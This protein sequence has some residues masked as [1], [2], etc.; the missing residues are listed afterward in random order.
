PDLHLSGAYRGDAG[1]P[2]G[3]AGRI[4]IDAAPSKWGRESRAPRAQTPERSARTRGDPTE[5]SYTKTFSVADTEAKVEAARG[6]QSFKPGDRRDGFVYVYSDDIELTINVGLATGRPI[7]L[8]GPSGSG[9]SSL[10][11]NVAIRLGRRY[12]ESII[13]SR[14]QHTDVQWH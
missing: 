2:T 12:Y 4:A 1:G 5:M 9:K 14:T 3:A 13:T 6:K 7:L 8:R 11:K 10:A